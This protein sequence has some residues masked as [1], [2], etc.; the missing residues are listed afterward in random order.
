[1]AFLKA[2]IQLPT[3]K[4]PIADLVTGMVTPAW[5]GFFYDLT[6]DATPFEAITVGASPFTYTAVHPGMML[7]IGGTVSAVGLIRGRITIA[8]T[9]LVAGFFPMAAKDQLVTTYTGVPTMWYIPGGV[10]A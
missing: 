1:M 8:A 3:M 9:G 2:P 4:Q 7:I 5:Y 6:S 10:P